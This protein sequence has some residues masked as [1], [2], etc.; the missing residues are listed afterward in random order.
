MGWL[1]VVWE[2]TGLIVWIESSVCVWHRS[3]VWLVVDW[4][5]AGL[6]VWIECTI[7]CDRDGW[8]DCSGV[9]IDWIDCMDWKQCVCVTEMDGLTAVV[10]EGEAWLSG[11]EPFCCLGYTV[12]KKILNFKQKDILYTVYISTKSWHLRAQMLKLLK[13]SKNEICCIF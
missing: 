10:W 4:E 12:P 8:F 2:S 1:V 5:L 3:M 7:V 6:I 11:P 13:F 9:R